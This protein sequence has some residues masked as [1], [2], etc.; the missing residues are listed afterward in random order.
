M[1]DN[2]VNY[3]VVLASGEIVNANNQLNRDLWLALK[4][5]SN[6]F[7][8]VTRFD[9]ITFEQGP[10]WGGSV[11]SDPSTF[12][13]HLK[14][15]VEFDTNPDYDEFAHII[16]SYGYGQGAFVAANNLY[17]TKAVVNPTALQ[18]FTSIKPQLFNNLRI[19]NLTDFTDEQAAFSTNGLR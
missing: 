7:G 8:I 13:Q 9:L 18:P 10:L 14:A 12:P 17:Y 16:V 5:G 11:Y 3:E 2:V 4:G 1:C 6:N 19:A 15:L